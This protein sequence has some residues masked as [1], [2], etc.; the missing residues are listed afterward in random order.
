MGIIRCDAGLKYLFRL[1]KR[2]FPVIVS[3][4]YVFISQGSVSTQLMRGG[5]FN[6][7]FIAYFLENVW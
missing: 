5:V 4:S 7:H 6:N 3:Y 1:P 2:F